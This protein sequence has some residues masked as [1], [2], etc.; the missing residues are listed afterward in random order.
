M[1]FIT[2]F[3]FDLELSLGNSV[4]KFR[5]ILWGKMCEGKEEIF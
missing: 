1:P 4:A 5:K 2:N 3:G